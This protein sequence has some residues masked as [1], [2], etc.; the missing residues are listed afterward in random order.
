LP[1]SGRKRKK[2]GG[3]DFCSRCEA[4]KER[5]AVALYPPVDLV[6]C[7]FIPLSLVYWLP[8]LTVWAFV[9]NLLVFATWA[10]PSGSPRSGGK[11][12]EGGKDFYSRCEATKEEVR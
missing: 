5:S 10:T 6:F 11:E 1:R 2:K 12:K 8:F 7:A 4:T 9:L 3:K